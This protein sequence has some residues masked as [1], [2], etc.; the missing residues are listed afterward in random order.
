MESTENKRYVA[1]YR[2]STES[3]RDGLGLD[4]QKARTREFVEKFGG[5]L[6]TEVEEIVSGGSKNRAEFDRAI[7]LCKA[8]DAILVVYRLDRMARDGYYTVYRLEENGI[9]Y[10]EVEAP[11]DSEFSKN[12]KFLLAKEE[13]EKIQRRV[14]EALGEIKSK[15]EKNGSYTTKDGKEITSLG[16][17]ENLTDKARQRSILVRRAKAISNENNIRAHAVASRMRD[18]GDGFKL[19]ADHLNNNSFKTS[20]GGKWYPASVSKLLELFQNAG[21]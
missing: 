11:F 5:K 20:R 19:I 14:K 3:Q 15:I 13:K 9:Q 10:V 17:P 12:I 7:E 21:A 16:T 4:V 1:Y 8:Y 6:I 18:Q 2:A